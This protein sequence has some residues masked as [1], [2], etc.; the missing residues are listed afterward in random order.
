[1]EKLTIEDLA[2][3]LAHKLQIQKKSKGTFS[4]DPNR[5]D[6]EEWKTNDIDIL[7]NKR[8]HIISCKPIMYPL[9]ALTEPI[10]EGGK[11]PIVELAKIAFKKYGYDAWID[12]NNCFVGMRKDSASYKFSYSIY[13]NSFSVMNVLCLPG[14][15]IEIDR[16]TFCSN[17][18]QLKL[19][20]WLYA[21]HF[22]LG[23]QDYFEKRLIIDKRTIK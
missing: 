7:F 11:I 23:S 18:L 15:R 8:H 9:S 20:K 6:I 5:I 10:L 2:P 22:W 21:H 13:H 4:C 12:G 17:Q 14:N 1:M 16:D 3:Y 19:F